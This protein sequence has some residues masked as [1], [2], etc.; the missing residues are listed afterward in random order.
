MEEQRKL[1]NAVLSGTRTKAKT[2]VYSG[3][4]W[5]IKEKYFF[6]V[7]SRFFGKCAYCEEDLSRSH[8]GE[9]EH[10]R[11][12]GEV[13][14]VDNQIVMIR[15]A[16]ARPKKH[17]GY[18]WLTYEWRNLLPACQLCNKQPSTKKP[19]GKGNR[20]PVNGK[21]ATRKGYEKREKPL[22]LNPVIDNPQTHIVMDVSGV[23][24]WKSSRGETTVKVLG[25]NERGLPDA[26]RETYN[27]ARA[28]YGALLRA[29]AIDPL[30]S[31][32][33]ELVRII[34]DIVRGKSEYALAGRKGISDAR[35][36]VRK[37]PI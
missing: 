18:Y 30:G 13:R 36:G 14:D 23:L 2:K 17:P 34:K 5:D 24:G 16:S 3:Y 28:R 19:F 32:A 20:F 15:S 9:M 31:E 25:L 11:P 12:K 4:N 29:L 1:N 37:A 35:R 10:Y 26:R 7:T 8:H 33:L 22:L 27:N 6:C 21:Y